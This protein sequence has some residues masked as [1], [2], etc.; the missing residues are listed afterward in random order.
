MWGEDIQSPGRFPELHS[1]EYDS[2]DSGL[3]S[4]KEIKIR[5]DTA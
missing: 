3:D 1:K 2:K 4:M 5:K